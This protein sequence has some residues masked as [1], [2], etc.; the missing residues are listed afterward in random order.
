MDYDIVICGG[1]LVGR[2]L[3]CALAK[4]PLQ[5]AV[6]EALPP[7]ITHQADFD[8]RSFALSYG[9]AL[10]LKQIGV[11]EYLADSAIPIKTI[12]VSDRGHSGMTRLKASE[13]RVPALGYIALAPDLNQA[14]QQTLLQYSN[15]TLLCP[16]AVTAID[17]TPNE[18][19]LTLQQSQQIRTRLAVAA[20]GTHS[21]LRQL[22]EI[23]VKQYNYDQTAIIANV[24]LTRSHHH[25]AYERFTQDGPIALLPLSEQRCG[26]VWTIKS[27]QVARV[28]SLTEEQFLTELQQ[29]FGYRLGRFAKVGKRFS[30]PLQLLQ[31]HQLIKPR[32]TLI[33]NAAHTLHPIAGQGFNLG[34]RDV[35]ALTS[36]IEQALA[37]QEDLGS[38]LVLSHYKRQQT[39]DHRHYIRF[40]DGLVKTFANSALPLGII[41]NTG[42]QALNLLPKLRK[43]FAHKAMGLKG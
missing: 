42:L 21:T 8:T 41:R 16:A 22:L 13:Q 9:N 6:V 35:A 31:A 25:V 39:Q 19:L 30:Y 23:P 12:H 3:A 33:G 36:L 29:A 26:L 14:L 28:M 27:E 1:G 7:K 24:G 4:L 10:F 40:T 38:E 15:V 34:L 5:I 20:D 18:A 17:C 11:W 37:K 32:V 2:S 43:T